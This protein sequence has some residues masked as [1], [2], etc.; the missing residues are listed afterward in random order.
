M[1]FNGV[2]KRTKEG[3]IETVVGQTSRE[4][5]EMMEASNNF[6][7]N[8]SCTDRRFKLKFADLSTSVTAFLHTAFPPVVAEQSISGLW[9]S[10][11]LFLISF[12]GIATAAITMMRRFLAYF[13][14]QAALL[15]VPNARNCDA[16]IG[17]LAG[18]GRSTK[19][20]RRLQELL[21]PSFVNP[22]A[23]GAGIVE[24]LCLDTARRMQ[25]VKVPVSE[26]I[27]PEGQV[28][29]SYSFWPAAAAKRQRLP[30]VVLIHGFDSSNLE[31]RRL[32]SRLAE[33]GVDTYA[34][35]LLGW[36]YTQLDGVLDFSAAAK[37]AALESFLATV[38]L[39]QRAA[40]AVL[41]HCGRQSRRR[42]GH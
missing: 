3:R 24:E 19:Q 15:L 39:G 16:L 27:H 6:A 18:G 38:V 4:P 2:C 14:L 20:Q 42:G 23:V 17:G 10:F 37:T 22:D 40:A 26:T 31:F 5:R 32:G 41:L 29:I 11:R 28:G 21:D 25:R 12:F 8:Q 34:V 36:G 30:P 35:D 7:A 13:S 9:V 33:R 1:A